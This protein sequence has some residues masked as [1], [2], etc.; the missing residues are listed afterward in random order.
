MTTDALSCCP[1]RAKA[2]REEG[3]P[4][5]ATKRVL[6]RKPAAPSANIYEVLCVAAALPRYTTTAEWCR[7]QKPVFSPF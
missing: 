4:C 3:D 7:R 5:L 6:S 2:R 1:A